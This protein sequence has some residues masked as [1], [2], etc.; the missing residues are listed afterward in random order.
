MEIID[1]FVLIYQ[2]INNKVSFDNSNTFNLC[3]N[4]SKSIKDFRLKIFNDY[5]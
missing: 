4:M 3:I 5:C 1:N 2:I